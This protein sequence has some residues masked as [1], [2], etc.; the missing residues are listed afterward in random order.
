MEQTLLTTELDVTEAASV[1][2][3]SCSTAGVRPKPFRPWVLSAI[4]VAVLIVIWW[5]VTTAA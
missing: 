1:E 3:A 5:A 2:W 4:T